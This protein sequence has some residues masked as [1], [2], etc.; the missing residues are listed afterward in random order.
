MN[1]N[2]IIFGN[3]ARLDLNGSFFATTGN[4]I[5]F[6]NNVNFS[7]RNP[8]NIPV[9][10]ENFEP[11]LGFGSKIE[12]NLDRNS[13]DIIIRGQ[14]HNLEDR[15]FGATTGR[16]PSIGLQVQPSRT[17]ALI[18][19]N[20]IQNGAILTGEGS[21]IELGSV[22]RGKVNLISNSFNWIFN[23]EQVLAFG[24]INLSNKSL[25]DASSPEF[26]DSTQFSVDSG[27][28][29]LQAANIVLKD[30][31]TILL[32]NRGVNASEN[33]VVNGTESLEIIG[34][35][36]QIRSSIR[37]QAL[38]KGNGGDVFVF[39]PLLIIDEGIIESNNFG[40]GKGGSIFTKGQE[41]IIFNGGTIVS[42]TSQ[43]VGKGGNI[44]IDA[45]SVAGLSGAGITSGLA[46]IGGTVGG[47][48]LAGVAITAAAP[49]AAAVGIGFGV[50]K[51]WQWL[52]K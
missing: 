51:A 49:A 3:G 28:I 1:P 8:Q 23:Y 45:G 2:G 15:G 10:R 16:N 47:G 4:S 46:A 40:S 17:L 5:D 22:K 12:V 7:A 18:G 11:G 29:R 25:I 52:N 35:V 30:G 27:Q 13:G 42:L 48:M 38:K 14:G 50:Y 39:T 33:I 44:T 19:K 34:S 37:T 21:R 6:G 9:I 31:S 41:A 43:E 20:I 32:Q 36:P 26:K 24:D